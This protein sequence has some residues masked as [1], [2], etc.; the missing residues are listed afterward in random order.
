MDIEWIIDGLEKPGKSKAGLAKALGRH[1][2]VVSNILSGKRDIKAREIA[3]ISR[4]L[5]TTAPTNVASKEQESLHKITTA[6]IVGDVA[7]GVWAEPG[8]HFEPIPSTIVVDDKWPEKSVYLLRVRGTSINRHAKD[9]DL[10]LCLDAYAAP[11]DFQH[12]DWVV[13]E[14]TDA[15]GR[16]ETTVKRVQGNR[17]TGFVLAPDSDDPAFQTP[18]RIG[19]HDG[20]AVEVKAF[21]LDFI[22]PA[23]TF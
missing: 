1:P 16:I 4:Y 7:A 13:A 20:E 10:V 18:I 14:R 11:R 9:G 22:K 5:E 6:F 3:I 19:K 21:V 2:A 15:D 12:G 17:H 23:T 8:V